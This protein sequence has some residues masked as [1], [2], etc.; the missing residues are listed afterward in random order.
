M[1][2]KAHIDAIAQGAVTKTN[3]IG[4]RKALNANTRRENGWSTSQTCPKA[5]HHQIE[6]AIDLLA[7]REP[8]VVGELHTTGMKQLRDRRYRGKLKDVLPIIDDLQHF[9][10]VGYE[11]N[12]HN[13]E[14][15]TPIY[16]AVDSRGRSFKFINV[17]WQSGGNGP[18]IVG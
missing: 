14:Q 8:V 5:D 13:G 3:V 15:A 18:E 4:I 1:S 9:K 6:H 17:P 10:L 11:M 7:E 2:F 16:R 12:G